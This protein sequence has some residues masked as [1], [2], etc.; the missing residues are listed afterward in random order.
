MLSG[1]PLLFDDLIDISDADLSYDEIKIEIWHNFKEKRKEIIKNYFLDIYGL[2]YDFITTSIKEEVKNPLVDEIFKNIT[3]YKFNTSILIA[4]FK[5]NRAMISE[6]TDYMHAD[7]RDMNFHAIGSGNIQAINTLLFQKHDKR[8]SLVTT[9]YDVY[10]A[11]RNAEAAQGV[12]KDTEL[13]ILKKDA[14]CIPIEPKSI[15]LLKNIY[16]EEL[17]LGRNHE[18]LNLLKRYSK[19]TKRCS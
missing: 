14:G 7:Y 9:I 2:D 15:E 19:V 11:K 13:V 12:G 1:N 10:K 3:K 5:E 8:D 18:K 4:G 17:K 6:I 16:E